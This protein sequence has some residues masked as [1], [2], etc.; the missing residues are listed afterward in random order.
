MMS[1]KGVCA[2]CLDFNMD[3]VV[4]SKNSL[5]PTWLKDNDY[6]EAFIKNHDLNLKTPSKYDV[7]IKVDLGSKFAGKKILYWAADKNINHSPL[8]KLAKNA[9]NKF[10]NSGVIKVNKD[11]KGIFK[12]DCPQIYRAKR[13]EKEKLKSYFRHMHFVIEKDNQWDTQIYTKI[14]IC[15]YDYEQFMKQ[16]KKGTTVIINALPNEYFAKDHIPNSYNLFNKT[17]KSMSSEQLL[18]WFKEVIKLHY[19]KLNTY[20]ENNKIELYEI[21]II[22]YCA[23]EKCNASEL[24]IKELM[25]KGFVNINEY[26]GGIVDYRLNNPHD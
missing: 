13:N 19:P 6:V 18:S 12:I 21:P 2:S 14:V 20:I 11:G 5:K 1:E 8:V 17:I 15:K 25:K 4:K 16:H 7:E 10:E 9:Y 22:T 23:H 26:S 24:A 3:K